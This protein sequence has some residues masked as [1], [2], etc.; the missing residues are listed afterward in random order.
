MSSRRW[1]GTIF[2]EDL[3]EELSR[4]SQLGAVR[5]V[6]GQLE[7]C[8]TTN[9]PHIQCY[10]ELESPRKF[11]YFKCQT[12][13]WEKAKGSSE[14]CIAYC[15]KEDTR[16]EDPVSFGHVGRGQGSRSDLDNVRELLDSGASIKDVAVTHFKEYCKYRHAFN[17]Y[18]VL[19]RPSREWE[20]EVYVLWGASGAGKTR[21]VYDRARDENLTVFPLGQNSGGTIWWDGY[22]GQDIVLIDDFYGWIKL[23]YMLKLLDRYPMNVQVKGGTVPFC[24]KIIYITSNKDPDTWYDW[25]IP[26]LKQAFFRRINFIEK[27]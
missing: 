1:I 9:R 15:T 8:P 12:A 22:I 21:R 18:L 27:Y 19:T 25:K 17:E 2:N 13:H 3:H 23:S 4:I 20:M 24:S 26:E 14:Q 5:Y 11:Q 10:V 16:V 7:C 6:T